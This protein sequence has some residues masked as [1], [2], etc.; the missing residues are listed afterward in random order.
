MSFTDQKPFIV[1]E[2]ICN[3]RWSGGARGKYFRCNLCGHRFVLGDVVR[4]IY[5]NHVKG[6][7]GNPLVCG[8]CDGP[9][10]EVITKWKK[11]TE[12]FKSD[13]FWWF[14]KS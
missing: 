12:E 10:S 9:N 7:G 8:K 4:W 13:K 2:E 14:R 1:T 6:A 5:S 3:S 11:L